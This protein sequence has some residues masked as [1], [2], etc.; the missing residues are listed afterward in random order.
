[1]SK[2]YPI[3][4]NHFVPMGRYLVKSNFISCNAMVNSHIHVYNGK[5]FVRMRI[6]LPYTRYNFRSFVKSRPK[7][8]TIPY[9]FK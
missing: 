7:A 2:V 5:Q 4:F 6:R 3:L 9:K 1:M 8:N